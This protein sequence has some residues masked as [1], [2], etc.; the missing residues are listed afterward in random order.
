[1]Q[2]RSAMELIACRV[3]NLRTREV[4]E[5]R[6]SPPSDCP[7]PRPGVGGLQMMVRAAAQRGSLLMAQVFMSAA[8]EHL[9][10]CVTVESPCHVSNTAGRK[11]PRVHWLWHPVCLLLTLTS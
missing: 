6:P 10:D 11:V 9:C 8:R 1:M 5:H 2:C 7:K 3:G 4:A